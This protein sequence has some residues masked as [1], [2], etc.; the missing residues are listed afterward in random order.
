M[1]SSTITAGA[2]ALPAPRDPRLWDG[3]VRAHGT[4]LKAVLRRALVRR[5]HPATAELL[6]DLVQEVWC[7]V[8]ERCRHRLAGFAAGGG[9]AH[10]LTFSYLAQT[11]R[12][13]ATDR[14]RAERAAKRGGGWLRHDEPGEDGDAVTSMPDPAPGPEQRLLAR[15]RR[16]G[17]RQRCRPYVS[18]GRA[19]RDL[20]IVERA[21]LDGWSSRQILHALDGQLSESSVDTLV[22]RVRRGLAS[23]GVRVAWRRRGRP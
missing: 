22:H 14:V 23:E 5:R 7:R 18:R 8:F 13:V 2:C 12:N 17:F 4:R 10:A 19:A 20:A 15:E 3:L 6:D 11:A 21:L 1:H 16:R 9:P